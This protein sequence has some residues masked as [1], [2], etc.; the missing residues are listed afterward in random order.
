DLVFYCPK[1]TA[2]RQTACP[3]L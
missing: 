3:K 1:C 2:E